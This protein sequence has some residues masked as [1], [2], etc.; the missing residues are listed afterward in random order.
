MHGFIELESTTGVLRLRAMDCFA[1]VMGFVD[2]VGR[3]FLILRHK[4][5]FALLYQFSQ[6][7]TFLILGFIISL[8][9]KDKATIYLVTST[10]NKTTK[11]KTP[12]NNSK[13]PPSILWLV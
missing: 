4:I 3:C 13:M 2:F 1:S 7:D 11:N 5:F 6:F 12:D 10:L 8:S 9:F